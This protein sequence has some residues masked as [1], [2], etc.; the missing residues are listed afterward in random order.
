[1]S[2]PSTIVRIA[3]TFAAW[4]S[5]ARGLLAA[6][7][8]PDQITWVDSEDDLFAAALPGAPDDNSAS[9]EGVARPVPREF[10]DAARFAAAYRD[11]ARW[12]LLYRILF[13]LTHG[14]R[15]L[16][17]IAT[18]PDIHRLLMME[19]AVRRDV[20]K[21]HAFVRFRKVERN[22]FD[23]YVAWHRP[24]HLSLRLSAPFFIERFAAMRWSILTPDQCIHWDTR[25][26]TY[27]PG[28]PQSAAPNHDQLESLWCTYYGAIFNPARIKLKAMKKEMP[29]RFWLSM[30]ETAQIDDLLS[31]APARVEEM[32]AR[33]S[34]ASA[35]KYPTAEAFLPA[36]DPGGRHSLTQLAQAA[37]S[38]RGCDLCEFDNQTVFGEGP[39]GARAVFV[40]EQPGDTEDRAGRPFVGPAGQL[41]DQALARVGI[42]RS[43]LYVTNAVKHFKY[44]PRGTRRIHATPNAREIQACKPWLTAEVQAIRPKMIVALGA[45]AAR[46][47]MG[48]SFRITARRGHVFTDTQWAPWLMATI[49]PSALLRIP[50]P[51]LRE[52]AHQQFLADLDLAARQ[53]RTLNA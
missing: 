16:M 6:D 42:D 20:H 32:M 3:P 21:T 8:P 19:K 4:R 9:A 7:T 31:A 44:E 35:S 25:A 13:R 26:A 29:V 52:T 51:A 50:D 36:P 22:G 33:S 45:T 18:D 49:H 10:L 47:L 53:L 37:R 17:A 41:L 46:T 40:G 43:L 11:P 38:C 2:A 30:P 28:L 1:M 48:P 24:D 5:V 34:A 27:T 39:P 12:S 23:H 15:H 14:Q